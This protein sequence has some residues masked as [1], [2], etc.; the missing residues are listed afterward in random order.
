MR[1][2]GSNTFDLI[3]MPNYY[4]I[5]VM[6]FTKVASVLCL[7]GGTPP[8]SKFPQ[9]SYNKVMISMID[10]LQRLNSCCTDAL[11]HA[12]QITRMSMSALSVQVC[13]G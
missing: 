2:A 13:H 10:I 4:H 5:Q 9:S 6:H 12:V 7:R 3:V 8:Q 1:G 11:I